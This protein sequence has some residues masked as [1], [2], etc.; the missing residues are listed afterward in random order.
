MPFSQLLVRQVNLSSLTKQILTIHHKLPNQI[1]A[2]HQKLPNQIQTIHHKLPNQKQTIHHKVITLT[3]RTR[4]TLIR[5]MAIQSLQKMTESMAM[6]GK[7]I[8]GLEMTERQVLL[9]PYKSVLR[10]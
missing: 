5:T 2:I 10:V 4:V 8:R 1:Q 6:I 3:L 9:L 7:I